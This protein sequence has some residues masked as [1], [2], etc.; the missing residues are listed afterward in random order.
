MKRCIACLETKPLSEFPPRKGS[1][2]GTRNM[3]KVCRK[4]SRTASPYPEIPEGMR[5]CTKCGA[6][7]PLE[8][9]WKHPKALDGR[10]RQ[11]GDCMLAYQQQYWNANAEELRAK[12]KVY[13]AQNQ[14]RVLAKK[15]AWY[16]ANRERYRQRYAQNP[17]YWRVRSRAYY[18]TPRGRLI[19]RNGQ[20]RRRQAAK[21]GDVTTAQLEALMERQTRCYYCKKPFAKDRP[22]TLDHI[23][24]LSKGG[25]HTISNLV[26]ACKPCNSRKHARSMFLL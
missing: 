19:N 26:L 17:E 20:A 8:A 9:F 7:K 10:R 3:C 4:A 22:A 18:K 6:I 13:V 15:R 12:A 25:E 1:P 2:D 11:C 24:P 21:R 16:E 5:R 23:I 14:D